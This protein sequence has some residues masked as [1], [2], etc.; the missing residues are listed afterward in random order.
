[1]R[2]KKLAERWGGGGV[3]IKGANE[4]QRIGRDEIKQKLRQK[5]RSCGAKYRRRTVNK[6]K[7]M[8]S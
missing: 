2:K 3:R 4:R 6:W 8:E 5:R 1:M 7:K